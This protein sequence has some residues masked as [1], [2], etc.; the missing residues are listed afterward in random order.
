MQKTMK[1]KN[2]IRNLMNY[3]IPFSDKEV[4]SGLDKIVAFFY[5]KWNLPTVTY[6]TII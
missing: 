5:I 6:D 1:Q 3:N 2:L 4:E